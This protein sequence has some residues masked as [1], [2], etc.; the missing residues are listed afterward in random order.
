MRA[1]KISVGIDCLN[2]VLRLAKF[3][4]VRLNNVIA[5]ILKE[6]KS[7]KRGASLAV[8]RKGTERW[9]N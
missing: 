3:K 4:I 6:G 9:P 2:S 8:D 5:K 7:C 1:N